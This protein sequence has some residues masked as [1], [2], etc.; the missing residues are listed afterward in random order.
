MQMTTTIQRTSKPLKL[1]LLLS[2]V[3][4]VYG[5]YIGLHQ[6]HPYPEAGATLLM[7]GTVT[8]FMTKALIWWNHA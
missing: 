1:M 3:A 7:G 4:A 6:P 8:W 5:L 2:H